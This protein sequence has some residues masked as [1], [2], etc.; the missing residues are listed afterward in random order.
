M[1][2][3]QE[4]TGGGDHSSTVMVGPNSNISPKRNIEVKFTFSGKMQGLDTTD[5]S[6]GTGSLTGVSVVPDTSGATEDTA[7]YYVLTLPDATDTDIVLTLALTGS[8]VTFTA[9]G[10][11]NVQTVRLDMSPPSITVGVSPQYRATSLQA[12]S[13]ALATGASTFQVTDTT[14][15]A[16][17]N[18]LTLSL[19]TL[20]AG[21]LEVDAACAS[22]ENTVPGVPTCIISGTD[23]SDVIPAGNE[24]DRTFTLR[25]TDTAGNYAEDTI[26]VRV[27]PQPSL[28]FSGTDAAA[29]T[30]TLTVT[31]TAAV[32]SWTDQSNLDLV[33]ITCVALTTSDSGSTY[34]GTC[35]ADGST[36]APT[37]AIST[38]AALDTGA[39]VGAAATF[40]YR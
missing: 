40:T 11:L 12:F 8:T 13:Q 15:D 27:R 22:F 20:S 19:V 5:L 28:A 38:S 26:T 33:G 34:S 14:D 6:V 9:A 4:K 32:A 7:W 24:A 18:T 39:S 21:G 25:A 3:L 29:G 2:L 37:A 23:T 31:W 17:S 1:T 36:A 30:S 10:S 16:K 35:T